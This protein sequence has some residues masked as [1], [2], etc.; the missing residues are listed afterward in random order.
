MSSSHAMRPP[1]RLCAGEE[2]PS[3][4]RLETGSQPVRIIV[5]CLNA[6]PCPVSTRHVPPLGP[7]GSATLARRATW[8][9][10]VTPGNGPT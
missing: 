5:R 3:G 4:A 6:H 9:L 10:R 1:S 2:Q 8:L 7:R